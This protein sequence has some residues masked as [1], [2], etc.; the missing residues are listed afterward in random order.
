VGINVYV[1]AGV[2]HVPMGTI[3]RGILP[4]VI[5]DTLEIILLTLF[6][7][8]VTFLPDLMN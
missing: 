8:I 5:A 7:Q 2:T 6:P 3:Y 1:I 4:F